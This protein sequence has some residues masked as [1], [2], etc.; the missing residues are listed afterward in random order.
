MRQDIVAKDPK[1]YLL[2]KCIKNT[3]KD[4]EFK[5]VCQKEPKKCEV[6]SIADIPYPPCPG[7]NSW[8]Y[9]YF[10]QAGITLSK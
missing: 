7:L 3:S 8:T 4:E 9:M 6:D 10:Q 5:A 2:L 1:Q